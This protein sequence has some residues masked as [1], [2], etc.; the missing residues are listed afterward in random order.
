M[1]TIYLNNILT[2]LKTIAPK[3]LVTLVKFNELLVGLGIETTDELR[4]W[5]IGEM[6]IK[7]NS[8]EELKYSVILEL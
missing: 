6:V 7:S 8:L 1:K 3:G 5:I 2:A 4:D